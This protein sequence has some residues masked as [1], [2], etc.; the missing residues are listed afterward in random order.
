MKNKS[1]KKYNTGKQIQKN[2]KYFN[3]NFDTYENYEDNFEGQ[4]EVRDPST[5]TK[6]PLSFVK[7]L[8]IS[9]QK[10]KY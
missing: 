10:K 5:I 3:S 8:N 9:V 4:F 1:T 2:T 7:D 6:Y